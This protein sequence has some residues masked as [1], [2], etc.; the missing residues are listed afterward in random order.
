METTNQVSLYPLFN[1]PL[2]HY[3]PTTQKTNSFT[4]YNKAL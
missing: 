2:P 3:I 4:P 1:N